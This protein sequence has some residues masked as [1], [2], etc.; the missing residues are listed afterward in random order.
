LNPGSEACTGIRK[1]LTC[2]N[3]ERLHPTRGVT[4]SGFHKRQKAV[5]ADRALNCGMS[6]PLAFADFA[7]KDQSPPILTKFRASSIEQLGSEQALAA[8]CSNGCSERTCKTLD[9]VGQRQL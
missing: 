2:D 9:S 5:V 4:A 8:L 6:V 1:W 3:A 7:E